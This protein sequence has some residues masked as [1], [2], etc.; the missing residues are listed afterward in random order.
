MCSMR[1]DSSGEDLKSWPLVYVAS[2]LSYLYV[3]IELRDCD[4]LLLPIS[5]YDD[6]QSGR[7]VYYRNWCLSFAFY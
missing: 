6:R 3:H 7:L 1:V 4:M 5:Q 2:Y